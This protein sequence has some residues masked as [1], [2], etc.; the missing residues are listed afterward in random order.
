MNILAAGQNIQ[1]SS[2]VDTNII[3][4]VLKQF[5]MLINYSKDKTHAQYDA[6]DDKFH[7][8]SYF[9]IWHFAV[10]IHSFKLTI[11]VWKE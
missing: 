11:I 4:I 2:G 5:E 10:S 6:V 8:V 1:V 7:S 3:G 9:K